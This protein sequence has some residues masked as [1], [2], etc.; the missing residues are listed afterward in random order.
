MK[1]R[2]EDW[3]VLGLEPGAT[4]TQIEKAYR[5]RRALY[6]PAALATYSL[7]DDNERSDMV[8]RIDLAYR[9]IVKDQ[10]GAR[11]DMGDD[12]VSPGAAT[13]PPAGPTPDLGLDPGRHLR[14]RRLQSQVSLEFV[15]A[16]TKIGTTLLEQIENEE[17]DALPAPVFVRGHVQQF[18]RAIGLENPEE[19]ARRYIDKMT[20]S[21]G[22][23]GEG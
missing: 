4:A 1:A 10:H 17:F 7:L 8:T 13:E 5:Q 20:G 2:D 3:E 21:G 19:I 9:R 12:K 11:Q 23:G 16:E 22:T 15:S 18:A 14:H 6:E